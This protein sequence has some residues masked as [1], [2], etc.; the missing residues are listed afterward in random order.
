MTP[1]DVKDNPAGNGNR[2]G[3]SR[4]VASVSGR[5]TGAWREA[6]GVPGQAT[7]VPR[8]TAVA[9]GPAAGPFPRAA[10]PAADRAGPGAGHPLATAGGSGRGPAGAAGAPGAGPGHPQGGRR[11]VQPEPGAPERA[12]LTATGAPA[13]FT[14]DDRWID[15]LEELADAQARA[16]GVRP[17]VEFEIPGL[18][19]TADIGGPEPGA[20]AYGAPEATRAAPDAGGP[21]TPDTAQDG[22]RPASRRPGDGPAGR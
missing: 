5:A 4:E 12:D 16:I 22:G 9:S 1:R 20:A 8:E 7:G 19:V 17:Q 14:D 13:S 11:P 18:R 6:A 10:S 3:A 15:E 21:A 2:T